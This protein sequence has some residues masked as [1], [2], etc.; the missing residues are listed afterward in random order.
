[1]FRSLTL[2]GGPAALLWG[3]RT[4]AALSSWRIGKDEGKWVLVATIRQ[5]DAFQLRQRP[6][7]FTAPRDKGFWAWPIT[8]LEVGPPY[9]SLRATLGPPEQ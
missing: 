6:L 7:L 9:T 1:M 3:H 5:A 2:R 4:A 8:T